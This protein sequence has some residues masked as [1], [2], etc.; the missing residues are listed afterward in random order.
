MP[1]R[2]RKLEEITHLV[3]PKLSKVQ[4]LKFHWGIW[5]FNQRRY[6][7]AHEVWE[8]I[9][10][11]LGND[12]EDD[13][14]IILRGL[15]QFAAGLHCCQTG[16]KTQGR[17]NLRKALVKFKLLQNSFGGIIFPEIVLKIEET[18]DSPRDLIG[19]QLPIMRL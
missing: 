17:G 14:E 1:P 13:W 4:L 3:E 8:D 6:W 19:Y 11:E 12:S 5:L 7:D 18:F 16:K 2:K 15:I 9:W 10:R